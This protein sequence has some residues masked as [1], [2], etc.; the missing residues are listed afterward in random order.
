MFQY[1]KQSSEVN[2]Q[3][4]T[5][6]MPVAHEKEVREDFTTANV[7]EVARLQRT[8]NAGKPCR[9][10]EFLRIRLQ[11]LFEIRILSSLRGNK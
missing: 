9:K 3:F 11:V 1:I 7:A 4:R 10:T 6:K 5:G 2:L 8:L